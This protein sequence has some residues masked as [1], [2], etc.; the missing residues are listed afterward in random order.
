MDKLAFHLQ[1]YPSPPDNYFWYN[2]LVAYDCR[3][4]RNVTEVHE[5]QEKTTEP[6]LDADSYQ[7]SQREKGQI[8]GVKCIVTGCAESLS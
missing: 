4:L 3:Q 1:P 6:G 8:C 7:K 2:L 5:V